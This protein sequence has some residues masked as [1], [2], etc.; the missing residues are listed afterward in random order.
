MV[1]TVL[2]VID[3]DNVLIAI[4]VKKL[5]ET[6]GSATDVEDDR[7]LLGDMLGQDV[8][9]SFVILDPLECFAVSLPFKS[10]FYCLKFSSQYSGFPKCL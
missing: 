9:Q 8:S 10:L 2:G 7:A 3:V 4:V 6:T 1:D 5:R